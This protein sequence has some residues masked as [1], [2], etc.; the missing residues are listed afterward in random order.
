MF[1]VGKKA[2]GRA[3]DGVIHDARPA[4]LP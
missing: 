1:R 4:P 3:L 2:A